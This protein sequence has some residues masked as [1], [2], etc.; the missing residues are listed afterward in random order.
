M[1]KLLTA[2]L[3]LL[4]FI[5]NGQS[6][7][8]F[9]DGKKALIVLTYDD[10]L[11][12]HLDVAIPQLDKAN[13][14]GTF[15]M[16]SPAKEEHIAR[17]REASKN[18]HELGNHT[19]YHPCL[20]TK[21]AMDPHYYSEKYSVANMIKEISTM[22]K[23]LTAIDGKM[24]HNFAYPC[25]ETEAGG[26]SYIDSLRQAGF[27][28]YARGVGNDPFI[29]DT[30]KLD[31]LK[32][33]CMGFSTNGPASEI[34]NF[35]KLVQEKKGIAVLIF[36]GVGGDYLEASAEAHQE[37]VNY[38]KNNSKDIWVATFDE[39]MNFAMKNSR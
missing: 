5:S 4:C 9:P 21:F 6:T 15:F 34:I 24:N 2:C 30:K 1:S 10:A 31:P 7:I 36:H 23:M 29:L 18:G 19:V 32:V 20:S 3:M 26:K 28:K 12:S 17:W 37:M 25:G 13:L 33:P 14:K 8:K 22:N 27:V 39:A 35:I 11:A 16:T 38:L